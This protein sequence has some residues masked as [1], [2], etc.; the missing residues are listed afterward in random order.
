MDANGRR[1]TPRMP[2]MR[3]LTLA[4]ILTSACFT[5][6]G[7]DAPDRE[8]QQAQQAIDAARSAGAGDYA[9]EEFNA[10]EKA[11]TTAREAVL[12]RDYRLA[13]TNAIDSR[14]RA[15]TAAK[16]A[17]DQKAIVRKATE[18]ALGTTAGA[19]AQARAR[20]KAAET[21]R[22]P[23]AALVSPRRAIDDADKAVQEA[24]AAFNTGDY[25]GAKNR[26]DAANAGLAAAS[27][28]LDTPGLTAPRRRR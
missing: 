22:P 19:V 11:L 21:V 23:R 4:L 10:A 28:D 18:R 1:Y 26:L 27:R 16:E 9:R 3:G 8:I 2:R 7:D 17:I 24:R 12:Q 15:Q 5:A 6:C 25:L 13:L 20:L 14:E